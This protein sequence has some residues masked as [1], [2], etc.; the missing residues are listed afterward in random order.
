MT[1]P[2]AQQTVLIT[3]AANG[4]G[5]AVARDLHENGARLVLLDRD[6]KRLTALAAELGPGVSPYAV[7]LADGAA[8]K[9]AVERIAAEG[10]TIDTLI[11][12]AAI[13][14]PEP[15]EAT[16]FARWSTTVNVGLQAG[17]LLTRAVWPGM[18][19]HGGTIIYVSSRSG[20]EGFTNESAYCAA[21]HG[22]EGMMK[23][24]AIEGAPFGI[25]VHT[26]TPGMYM[27]TPMSEHNYTPDLKA[28]WVDPAELAPAF[29]MLAERA[30]SDLSGQRLSAW[31]L[32]QTFREPS[33]V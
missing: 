31:E 3:G 23:C 26:V 22:L 18:K 14:E 28:L 4:L 5:A 15:F 13:L 21:K 9:E 16:T 8:T 29:R 1:R 7:D 27:R 6:G 20:I 30:D 17:F 25:R 11:H 24:L 19:A 10:H 33:H 12:N 32:A 2:V